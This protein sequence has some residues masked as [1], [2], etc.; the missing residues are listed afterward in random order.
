[1]CREEGDLLHKAGCPPRLNEVINVEGPENDQEYAGCEVLHR[2]LERDADG[3]AG[4]AQQRYQRRGV[5]TECTQGGDHHDQQQR[6]VEDGD[7]KIDQ[8]LVDFGPS[9]ILSGQLDDQ[10][11]HQSPDDEDGNGNDNVQQ[12]GSKGTGHGVSPDLAV[13]C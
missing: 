6:P 7:A 11:G 10:F 1:M 9:E 12:E 8:Q 3:D 13:E 4:S 5:N 2:I